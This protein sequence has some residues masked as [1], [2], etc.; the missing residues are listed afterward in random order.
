MRTIRSADEWQKFL[1]EYSGKI[2]VKSEYWLKLHKEEWSFKELSPLA[3]KVL[4]NEY[5]IR[6]VLEDESLS[7]VESKFRSS[8]V[9][10]VTAPKEVIMTAIRQREEEY[11][12]HG[13]ILLIM[14]G[15]AVGY[16]EYEE[17]SQLVDMFLESKISENSLLEAIQAKEEINLCKSKMIFDLKKYLVEEKGCK[18]Y[19]LSDETEAER[20]YNDLKTF[21]PSA[22]D[23]FKRM[24]KAKSAVEGYVATDMLLTMVAMLS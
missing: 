8:I 22:L 19:K 11:I 9:V 4:E 17:A 1:E 5:N 16:Q 23:L 10:I 20:F 3:Q 7:D 13:K 12:K 18:E 2:P 6:A 24:I 21:Y 14:F 15:I